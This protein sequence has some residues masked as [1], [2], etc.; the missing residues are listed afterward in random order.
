MPEVM[1]LLSSTIL[2]IIASLML[3][4]AF[5]IALYLYRIYNQT[6]S[7]IKKLDY[8]AAK[9]IDLRYLR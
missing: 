2:Y 7:S 9:I 8:I 3:I 1:I 4:E 6:Q 5:F